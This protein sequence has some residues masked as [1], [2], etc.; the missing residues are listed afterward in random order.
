MK[1]T[2]EITGFLSFAGAG[3]RNEFEQKMNNWLENKNIRILFR[4]SVKIFSNNRVVAIIFY[5]DQED[6]LPDPSTIGS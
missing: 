1:K 2:K 4:P 3:E 5:E 6:V